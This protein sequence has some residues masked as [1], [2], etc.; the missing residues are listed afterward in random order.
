[1]DY[2][3]EVV[4]VAAIPVEKQTQRKKRAGIS[5]NNCNEAINGAVMMEA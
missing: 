1:M 2:V 4:E 5:V 3:S